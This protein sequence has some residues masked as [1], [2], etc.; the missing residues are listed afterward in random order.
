M[1]AA[2]VFNNLFVNVFKYDAKYDE[3]SFATDNVDI[4]NFPINLRSIWYKYY[5]SLLA[6]YKKLGKVY[7]KT[8]LMRD[9]EHDELLPFIPTYL[10]DTN[11]LGTR[12]LHKLIEDD[13]KF[14]ELDDRSDRKHFKFHYSIEYNTPEVE[15]W[16]INEYLKE[17]LLKIKDVKN[18]CP[19]SVLKHLDLDYVVQYM[20]KYDSIVPYYRFT[21]EK[22]DCLIIPE[23]LKKSLHL[24]LADTILENHKS[25]DK[26]TDE[27]LLHNCSCCYF[28]DFDL[29]V[30]SIINYVLNEIIRIYNESESTRE[31]LEKSRTKLMS[32]IRKVTPEVVDRKLTHEQLLL[33][34]SPAWKRSLSETSSVLKLIECNRNF[35]DEILN[36]FP[37]KYVSWFN[38]SIISKLITKSNFAEYW[39]KYKDAHKIESNIPEFCGTWIKV[40]HEEP[41]IE[42]YVSPNTTCG[43]Y[44]CSPANVWRNYVSQDTVP[45]EMKSMSYW[46][47]M[48]STSGKRRNPNHTVAYSFFS[49]SE[50]NKIVF[51]RAISELTTPAKQRFN[52]PV[53]F[54]DLKTFLTEELITNDICSFK[55]LTNDDWNKIAGGNNGLDVV[56]FS[57]VKN[58]Y[59]ERTPLRQ[60]LDYLKEN[61]EI[62][63]DV[64]VDEI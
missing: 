53:D 8:R 63:F 22:C 44:N 19:V 23:T 17:G 57:E 34:F 4:S 27:T 31:E 28:A 26:L 5:P 29:N 37:K 45:N 42:L 41:P 38:S 39:N 25:S 24:R 43:S 12:V 18:N 7:D 30:E 64:Q 35:T 56:V 49:N 6:K 47:Y 20:N 50:C 11:E 10:I 60:V 48:I 62:K 55:K 16:N 1:D 2:F 3:L 9:I 33:L 40:Y 13:Y 14:L 54:D 52:I 58:I 15:G 32:S 51:I 21:N 59:N 36:Q 46:Q 61:I